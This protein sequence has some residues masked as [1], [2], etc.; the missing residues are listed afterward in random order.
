MFQTGT[1]T[2]VVSFNPVEGCANPSK[3]TAVGGGGTGFEAYLTFTVEK[4]TSTD[5]IL[6]SI[7]NFNLFCRGR[8]T[9]TL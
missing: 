8:E 5:S 2:G 3:F 6:I 7:F 9:W 1:I 4:S